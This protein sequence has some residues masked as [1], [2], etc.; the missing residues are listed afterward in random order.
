MR[1]D[2]GLWLAGL[3]M[4]SAALGGCAGTAA[5]LRVQMLELQ[6]V[7]PGEYGTGAQ[8]DADVAAGTDPAHPALR[9]TIVTAAAPLVGD[10][11]LYVEERDAAEQR[12]LFGQQV[13]VLL[14]G[15]GEAITQLVYVPAEP[16]RWRGAASSPDLLR[17]MLPEDLTQLAG[18]EVVWK[19]G[20]DGGYAAD[21]D[22]AHCRVAAGNGVG[23]WQQRTQWRVNR[24]G[25]QRAQHWTDASG[26]AVG[27]RYA[28]PFERFV[29]LGQ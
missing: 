5:R 19:R 2:S 14:P 4:L 21:G 17:Q 22:A 1:V 25:V 24:Q 9:L 27:T 16:S 18:C 26:A 3:L 13:W 28:E 8:H 6:A 23:L 10:A 7:L 15:P 12:R 11:V 29:R 20:A